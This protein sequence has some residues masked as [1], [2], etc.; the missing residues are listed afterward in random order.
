VIFFL[1]T[2]IIAAGRVGAALAAR[3]GTA[4]AIAVAAAS[5]ALLLFVGREYAAWDPIGFLR[6][7]YNRPVEIA[8]YRFLARHLADRNENVRC[9]IL[10]APLAPFFGDAVEIVSPES[11]RDV[12]LDGTPS[13][14]VAS[15]FDLARP[16]KRLVFDEIGSAFAVTEIAREPVEQGELRLFRIGPRR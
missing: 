14:L 16:R 3:L 2:G 6:S 9:Y 11:A 7:P 15:T 13:Y 8:Q 4:V 12:R 5:V 10:S 1:A